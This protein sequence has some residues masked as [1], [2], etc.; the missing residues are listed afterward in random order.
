MTKISVYPILTTPTEED[1]LI[2]TDVNSSD[3]TKNFSIGSIINL[4]GDINQGP[5]GPPGPQGTPGSNGATNLTTVQ[6]QSNFTIN[7]D[8]GTDAVVPLGNGTFAGATSNDYTTAEKNKLE[9][10]QAGAEVNVNAD[11]NATSGDAQ[12]LN[13]PT[14]PD[15]QIQSDWEQLNA[16][17]L[18]Y[19]KNKPAIP[20]AQV[21]SNWNSTSGISEI[22]NKPTIPDAQIQS[23]WTQANTSALDYIKNKPTVFNTPNLQQVTDEGFTTFD[24]LVV[25]TQFGETVDSISVRLIDDA[26]RGTITLRNNDIKDSFCNIWGA[27]STYENNFKLPVRPIEGTYILATEDQIPAPRPYKVYTATL[28]QTG[29]SSPDIISDVVGSN[30]IEIGQTYEIIDNGSGAADFTNIGAPDNNI[31]TK[32]VA[33]GI[34]PN[35]W[36]T[37][38]ELAVNTGAPVPTVLENTIG[39]IWFEYEIGTVGTYGVYSNNL[40]T[41]E[42]RWLTMNGV[43]IKDDTFVSASFKDE[44]Y[45]ILY[46][47]NKNFIQSNGLMEE[48]CL[49]IRV[50]N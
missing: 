26:G 29:G 15:A 28:T 31:G 22:L 6:T 2:G 19:I 12:I 49:E 41:N 44:G 39:N 20:A 32:F 33:T 46:T 37:T 48:A 13:K 16:G 35:D 9:G 8:T 11:W 14:I 23:D 4:I 50:Y 24:P 3:E 27:D 34:T 25:K 47:T 42:K 38:G 1:I 30:P 21:N 7:S 18:D 10:I 17:S 45:I 43:Q 40:F 5:P 36:G